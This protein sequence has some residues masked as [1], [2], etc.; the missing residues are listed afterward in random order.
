MFDLLLRLYK[1]LVLPH[2]G[3][4]GKHLKRFLVEQQSKQAEVKDRRRNR[5]SNWRPS[6]ADVRKSD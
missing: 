5:R 4:R 1:R 6:D 2:G 3:D